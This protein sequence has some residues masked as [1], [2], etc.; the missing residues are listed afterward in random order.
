MMTATTITPDMNQMVLVSD[1]NVISWGNGNETEI[2][3]FIKESL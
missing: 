2:R 3:Y 1:Q